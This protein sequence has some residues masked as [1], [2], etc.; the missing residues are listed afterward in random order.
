MDLNK[1]VTSS[2]GEYVYDLKSI[3]NHYGTS[4]DGGHCNLLFKR[5]NYSIIFIF[6]IKTRL[7]LK[8]NWNGS[9]LTTKLVRKRV[10]T[11]WWWI[12][13]LLFLF[14]YFQLKIFSI[15]L[16]SKCLLLHLPERKCII[17]YH[18]N[19]NKWVEIFDLHL[20]I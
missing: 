3:C 14:K 11:I 6:K 10:K 16:D 20:L 18:F 7:M 12:E 13:K 15:L 8:I 1:Y 4:Y 5:I 17:F 9:T 19:N 2:I